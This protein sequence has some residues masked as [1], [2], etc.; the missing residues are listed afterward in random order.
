[1]VDS[2]GICFFVIPLEPPV[3]AIRHSLGVR[4]GFSLTSLRCS[5]DALV[6]SYDPSKTSAAGAPG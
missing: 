4:S 3:N 2:I 1:M 5:S 6:L